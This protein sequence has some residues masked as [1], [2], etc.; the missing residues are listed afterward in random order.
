VV[1]QQI[2]QVQSRLITGS[3]SVD[4]WAKTTW[5][6]ALINV[7]VVISTHQLLLDAL[8]HGFVKIKSVALL[9]L[10]EGERYPDA[11]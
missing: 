8:K 9:I 3:D 11:A 2:P 5:E 1:K 4:T 10:D 7:K 6:T